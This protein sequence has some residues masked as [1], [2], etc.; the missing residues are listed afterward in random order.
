[1]DGTRRVLFRLPELIA[2][3][4]DQTVFVVEGEK[5][6]LRLAELGLIATTNCGGSGK[7]RDEYSQHLAG[8]RVVVLPDA[9]QPG[10]KHAEQVAA[11][12]SG[13][14]AEIRIVQLPGLDSKQDVS[15]WLDAGGTVEGLRA[16]VDETLTWQPTAEPTFHDHVDAAQT[17]T[18]DRAKQAPPAAPPAPWQPFPSEILPQPLRSY[19]TRG[20]AA[21][22]CD[23]SFVAVPILAVVAAAVGTSRVIRL[24]NSWREPAVVWSCTIGRSGTM[25]SPSW[26]LAVRPLQHFQDA[27]FREFAADQEAYQRE[28]LLYE[29]DLAAWKK[30][31]RRSGE[32]PPD[33]P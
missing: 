18:R 15:D 26:E 28:L 19:V 1:M 12:L 25:K 20:A 13:I 32:P 24:K 5:D 21:L 14:A 3:D 2:A 22:G 7:W 9:D 6:C 29:A 33:E 16:L 27:A 11:A 30:T 8:R 17:R 4:P 10:A 23:E 31:G